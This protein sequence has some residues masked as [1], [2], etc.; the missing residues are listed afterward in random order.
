MVDL[1]GVLGFVLGVRLLG[2]NGTGFF[3]FL[4]RMDLGL[5]FADLRGK[6]RIRRITPGIFRNLAIFGCDL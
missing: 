6:C 1:L 2:F 3:F 5:E 4:E